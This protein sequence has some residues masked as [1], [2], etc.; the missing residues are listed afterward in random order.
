M[1]SSVEKKYNGFAIAS[2]VLGIA[3][4]VIG[5][6]IL[7]IPSIL[8][9]IFGHI[10]LSQIKRSQQKLA[11]NGM[12][13]A[14]LI[15]GYI[16]LVLMISSLVAVFVVTNISDRPEDARIAKAKIDIRM[17]ENA[18]Q[19]YKLDNFSYPSTEQGLEALVAKP[20]G[21]PEPKH[22]RQGGYLEKLPK[23]PWND[24]Y[25]YSNPGVHGK[26]DIYSPGPD[27]KDPGDDIGNWDLE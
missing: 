25:Q 14:G 1:T 15:T 11:G 10:S 22:Y 5:W 4:L 27:P 2:M 3:G 24:P 19:L 21:D 23:D 9:V 6:L 12:A 7:F 8:A 20:S 17:L 18:L 26:I 13:I 16:G